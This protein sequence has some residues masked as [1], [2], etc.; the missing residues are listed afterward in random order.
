MNFPEMN[1]ACLDMSDTIRLITEEEEEDGK[2]LIMS[3][4]NTFNWILTFFSSLNMN[5][6]DSL[7]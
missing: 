3:I 1:S 5:M 4:E 7:K 2:T 6:T